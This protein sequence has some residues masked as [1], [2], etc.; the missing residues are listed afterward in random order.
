VSKS[1]AI[2]FAILVNFKRKSRVYLGTFHA[3]HIYRTR[4]Q[5]KGEKGLFW[6]G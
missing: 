1:M 5:C 4:Y 3:E 2:D 6:L